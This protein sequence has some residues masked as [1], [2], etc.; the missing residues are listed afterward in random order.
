MFRKLRSSLFILYFDQVTFALYIQA[1]YNKERH[2]ERLGTTMKWKAL[3]ILAALT[4][5]LSACGAPQ[6]TARTYTIGIVTLAPF[7]DML[8]NFKAEMA[9]L[10]Y[11]EGKNVT[12]LYDGP[13][14]TPDKLEPATQR[15]V[16]AKVDA[17]LSITTTPTKIAKKVTAGTNTPVVFSVV[18]DP[19]A[20]GIIA[21]LAQPGGNITG[22]SMGLVEGP[23]MEW[24]KKLVPGIQRVYVPYNPKDTAASLSFKGIS[25]ATGA[26][27]ISVV[28]REISTL[29][30]VDAA[31]N[32]I[33]PDVDAIVMPADIM[34]K[35]RIEA[36]AKAAIAHKLPLT[37][38]S[39]VQLGGLMVYGLDYTLVGRQTARLMQ[40]VLNGTNP[41]TIP[42][43]TAEFLLQLNLK[44]A[45]AI[46][47]NI[48]DE[49]LR[50]ARIIIR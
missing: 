17:I 6:S 34:V 36:L 23:R 30:D 33:P 24:L 7:D 12:Y 45:H 14:G 42:V 28:P 50:Q 29:E 39:D 20:A 48:P 5:L 35:N 41:G 49:I 11:V 8:A 47:L 16:D 4:G 18:V 37:T 46:D 31:I 44:T 10:G 3:F 9:E 22:V 25:S 15:L 26:L 40:K 1:Q 2:M 32:E 43:E 13:T 21:T 27:G 38:P 19:I